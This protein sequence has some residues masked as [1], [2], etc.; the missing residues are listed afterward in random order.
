MNQTTTSRAGYIGLER[1]SE[2]GL[3]EHGV[4]KYDEGIGRFI[5]P[6]ALWE[7]YVGWTQN[8]YTRNHFFSYIC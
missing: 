1:D 4:R 5:A 7:K 3:A 6:D 8:F 2:L